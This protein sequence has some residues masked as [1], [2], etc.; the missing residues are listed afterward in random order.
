MVADAQQ[1]RNAL[2][3]RHQ[4]AVRYAEARPAG[5][6]QCCG[7]QRLHRD[8][9]VAVAGRIA[10]RQ[11]PALPCGPLAQ[12]R[13]GG[14]CHLLGQCRAQRIRRHPGRDVPHPGPADLR[15]HTGAEGHGQQNGMA[16]AGQVAEDVLSQQKPGFGKALHIPFQPDGAGCVRRQNGHGTSF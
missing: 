4:V 12:L 11:I 5:G 14:I 9:P 1:R 7:H 13:L 8:G 15:I 6:V 16:A 3:G 10:A 2:A